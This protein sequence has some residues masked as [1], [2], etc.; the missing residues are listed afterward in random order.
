M[1]VQKIIAE[2]DKFLDKGKI[3]EAVEKLKAALQAEPMNQ[4][5]T[6]KLANAYAAAGSKEK[7]AATFTALANRLSEAGKAQVAIAV[8]KQAIELTPGDIALK[9][10]YAQECEGVGKLSDAQNQAQGVF[11]YYL[12]RKKYFDA[13][14][15]LPMLV[16]LNGKDERLK[17]AWLEVM[18]LSQ[19][20]KKL[21]HLLVALAGPP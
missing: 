5:A 8:Y 21:V 13:A 14:N 1:S 12:R 16:R 18:Q 2:A 20:E 4:L 9:L 19:A 15:I 11:Q 6:T 10:R 3:P 7:A 17:Q